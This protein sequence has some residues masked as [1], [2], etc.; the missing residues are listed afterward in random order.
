MQLRG[1]ALNGV[2]A[3]KLVISTLS[4]PKNRSGINFSG[5]GKYLALWNVS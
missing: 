4:L 2:Y 3:N 1:P 5:S